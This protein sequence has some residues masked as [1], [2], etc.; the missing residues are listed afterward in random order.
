M[1]H[2]QTTS[3][4]Y[5]C[6][7]FKKFLIRRPEPSREFWLLPHLQLPSQP[8]ATLHAEDLS[9]LLRLPA[10]VHASPPS[11]PHSRG[12]H[13]CLHTAFRLPSGTL[14]T[15]YSVWHTE[16]LHLSQPFTQAPLEQSS[17][18]HSTYLVLDP[19][20]CSFV[21]FSLP[22]RLRTHQPLTVVFS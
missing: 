13:V 12:P 2:N 5:L 11:A 22:Q 9:S 14:T 15:Q 7:C 20:P 21:P 16:R 10:Q 1:S 4:H 8:I 3:C 6:C 19:R 17:E 18:L